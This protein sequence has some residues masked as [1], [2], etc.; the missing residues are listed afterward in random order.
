MQN[1]HNKGNGVDKNQV[2]QFM[3][4]GPYEIPILKG[5]GGK[6]IDEDNL[7]K[8]WGEHEL[9]GNK[10]GCYVFGFQRKT[11]I[12]VY[13]G[14]TIKQTFKRECFTGH[15]ISHYNKALIKSKKGK[16]IMFFLVSSGKGKP[17]KVFRYLENFLIDVGTARNIEFRNIQKPIEKEK[18]WAI[19]GVLR[20]PK[21]PPSLDAREF[22]K[23]MGIKSI[24]S[25][26]NKK[27]G[28]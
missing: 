4:H 8:F 16:P 20:G 1:Q 10:R 5:E 28:K 2:R 14:R 23:M 7:G 3:V 21:G 9:M 12:P 11:C 13:A 6:I 18:K 15:K 27:T 25:N 22:K 26:N 17:G 24:A 19:K